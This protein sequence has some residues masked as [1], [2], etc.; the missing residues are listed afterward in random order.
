MWL[1]VEA[2]RRV[3][4]R[5]DRQ[6]AKRYAR[7]DAAQLD[8]DDFI[9]LARLSDVARCARV[10][11]ALPRLPRAYCQGLTSAILRHDVSMVRLLAGVVSVAAERRSCRCSPSSCLTRRAS[12]RSPLAMAVARLEHSPDDRM[13]LI[14]LALCWR[15][16][17]PLPSDP[18][19]ALLERRRVEVVRAALLLAWGLRRGVWTEGKPL[20]RHVAQRIARLV[21]VTCFYSPER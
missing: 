18:R 16:G 17:E 1:E 15:S 12:S 13:G 2:V 4:S 8:V 3:P 20:D 14:V 6:R 10:D 5:N 21:F 7:R 19:L 11:L 9:S